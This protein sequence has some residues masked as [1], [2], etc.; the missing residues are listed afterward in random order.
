MCSASE[1]IEARGWWIG[2]RI[3]LSKESLKKQR[4][5]DAIPQQITA[6]IHDYNTQTEESQ[7]WIIDES[8]D[9][10][11]VDYINLNDAANNYSVIG[12]ICDN[13]NI[14]IPS[15][16][17]WIAMKLDIGCSVNINH[18]HINCKLEGII[19]SYD[20]ISRRHHITYNH[21]NNAMSEWLWCTNT[22]TKLCDNSNHN[23][24]IQT[25]LT[26]PSFDVIPYGLTEEFIQFSK[27]MQSKKRASNPANSGIEPP[28]KKRKVQ[29]NNDTFKIPKMTE[30]ATSINNIDDHREVID[31][32]S[33]QSMSPPNPKRCKQQQN[34]CNLHIISF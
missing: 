26:A 5:N 13:E 6:T 31:I 9:N 7:I 29:S 16:S 2:L 12:N 30:K 27:S 25:Q 22:N 15:H 28:N 18:K 1:S 21:P 8:G 14:S 3:K 24:F 20:P 23:L 32:V 4:E 34:V 19:D 17:Q 10:V 33:S 11:Y